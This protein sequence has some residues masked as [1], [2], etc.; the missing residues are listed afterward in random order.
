VFAGAFAPESVSTA[1]VCAAGTVNCAAHEMTQVEDPVPLE[2]A[3][4]V[5]EPDAAAAPSMNRAAC[6]VADETK[7]GLRAALSA[8]EPGLPMVNVPLTAWVELLVTGVDGVALFP[9]PPHEARSMALAVQRKM[10]S[11]TIAAFGPKTCE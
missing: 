8:V 7:S 3:H 11:F 2:A 1:N 4:V 10:G 5:V 9:P 6:P